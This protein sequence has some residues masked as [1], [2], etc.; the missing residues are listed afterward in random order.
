MK[1]PE[2]K[3]AGA[4]LAGVLWGV[5]IAFIAGV[6]YL[7][8]S[9]ILEYKSSLDYPTTVKALAGKAAATQGWLVRTSPCSIPQPDDKSR[10]TQLSLCNAKFGKEILNDQ[11][12]RKTAAILPCT[13][14]VYEKAD[15][16]TYISRLNV[17]LVGTILG[18]KAEPVMNSEISPDH[19][20]FLEAAQGGDKLMK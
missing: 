4:F 1:L 9:L 13:F 17:S 5:L 6:L 12:S 18:G 11:N 7:R 20:T 10:I 2:R 8:H 16:G 3:Y 15:G 14:A 19:K